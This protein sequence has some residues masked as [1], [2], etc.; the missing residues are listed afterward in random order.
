[1]DELDALRM[2]RDLAAAEAVGMLEGLI[3]LGHIPKHHLAA[4]KA[5]VAKFDAAVK[6][7]AAPAAL[8]ERR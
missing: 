2:D 1:M 6:A 3:G 5:V 8:D 4:A 7:I